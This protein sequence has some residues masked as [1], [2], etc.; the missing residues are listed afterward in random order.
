MKPVHLLHV[1]AGNG[2]RMAARALR[3]ALDDRRIPN[4][5]LDLIDFSNDLFKWS[6]SDVYKFISEHAHLACKIM[7]ELTDQDRDKSL[8]LR[9]V[10]RISLENVKRFLGY[11]RENEPEICVC[12]HFFPANVLSRMKEEG[13]YR[14]RIY[15]VVTDFALH[16]MWMSPG[17]DRYFAA[18]PIVVEDLC[19]LGVPRECISLTGI[20]VLKKYREARERIAALRQPRRDAA[21]PLSVLFVTSGISDSLALNILDDLRRSGTPADVTVVAGRNR[22]LL[23]RLEGYRPREGCSFRAFGF[24]ENLEEYL[25]E[26]DLLVTKP[27]GLTASEA[28]SVGVPMILVS[29]V[30]YQEVYNATYLERCGA[31]V[32]AATS[33]DVMRLLTDLVRE[34]GR[35]DRMREQ[36]LEAG[37]PGASDAV[38]SEILRDA[39]SSG[40]VPF[41]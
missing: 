39:A 31:G 19:G 11:V 24:V 17:V 16:R 21:S 35:L 2:H 10:E 14:G 36:A 18:S 26:A 34:E 25:A 32:L 29:P 27:G 15:T 41:F 23:G 1:T 9:F 7:Y 4:V 38:V 12:T 37:F 13:L 3:E 30:P 20:P 40:G 33:E 28:L 8:M 6:Y 22:D 5:V